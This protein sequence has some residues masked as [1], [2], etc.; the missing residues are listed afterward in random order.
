MADTRVLPGQRPGQD[1]L[2][3]SLDSSRSQPPAPTN[4][5]RLSARVGVRVEG[6]VDRLDLSVEARLALD[7]GRGGGSLSLAVRVALALERDRPAAPQPALNTDAL[8]EALRNAGGI[9][10][11]RKAFTDAGL[12]RIAALPQPLVER[13]NAQTQAIAD[14]PLW[15]D[16]LTLLE[17]LAKDPERARALIDRVQRALDAMRPPVVQPPDPAAPGGNGFRLELRI[18]IDL[19]GLDLNQ[20]DVEVDVRV[21]LNAVDPL[22]LDLDGN[23]TDLTTPANGRWFDI[24]GDGRLDRTAFVTGNDAFLALDR[25]G[26]GRIDSGRELFGEQHGAASGFAE[27]AR[28]DEDGNGRIDAGDSV[29]AQLVL[30]FGDGRT[31][32]L[33]A[34]GIAAI[35]LNSRP[36]DRQANG[37]RLTATAAFV[38]ADG[39]QGRV[40]DA[41]LN[42]LA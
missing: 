5:A 34:A 40:Y 28:F 33:A 8:R 2:V 16:Y 38:R 15:R 24:D 17:H 14:D 3:S 6:N 9:D 22:V 18:D 26:N 20:L 19:S 42:V 36:L 35:E 13:I 25:N 21:S 12:G 10:E 39:G 31:R 41:L 29:F 32:T 37:N 27:L 7:T 4:G 23:G 11:L 1:A 30:L